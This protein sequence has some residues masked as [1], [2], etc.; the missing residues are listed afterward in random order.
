LLDRKMDNIHY[1]E[2][3]NKRYTIVQS[4]NFAVMDAF[5]IVCSDEYYAD[6]VAGPYLTIEEAIQDLQSVADRHAETD[7]RPG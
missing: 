3:D 1:I 6:I 2:R 4:M 5:D 7:G